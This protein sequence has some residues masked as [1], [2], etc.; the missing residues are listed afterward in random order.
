MKVAQSCL[1]LCDPIDYIVRG[2]LQ[3][4][5]L[6][7]VAFSF[8]RVLPKPGI[9]PRSPALQA[10]SLSAESQGKPSEMRQIRNQWTI[11]AATK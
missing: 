9:E 8:S 5:I 6:E 2:I 4:R 11:N 3:T 10:G 1:T 7:W